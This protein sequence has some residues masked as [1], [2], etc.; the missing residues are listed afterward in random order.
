LLSSPPIAIPIIL[1][2]GL[3]LFI[4]NLGGAPL[5]TKGEPREAVTVFDI[6]H[7]GGV[8]LPLRAGVEIPSKPLLMHWL[9]AIVSLIAGRVSAWTVRLPSATLAIAGMLITYL[10]VR[11]MFEARGALFAALMLGTAF[12]YLQAGTGSR[13][14]MTLTFFMTVAF[15]E[16]LAI[17]ERLSNRTTLLY[18]ALALAVLTK[19]PVGAA[20]PALV[21]F[22]WIALAWRWEVLKRLHLLR[23][24][25][26]VGVIGGGWYLAA[27]VVGG[28]AFVHKQ[29]L[30]EN[31][32]RLIGHA[33]VNHGHAHPFYYEELALLAG[34]MPWTPL[35]LLAIVQAIRHPRRL[36]PRLGYLLV[37][38]LVV[39][40]FYNLPQSK[41]GVYLLAL[42]PALATILALYL[43]DAITHRAMIA[44]PLRAFTRG[45][46]LFFIASGVLA[47]LGLALLFAAP[48]AIGYLL[49]ECGIMLDQLP[50]ALRTTAHQHGIVSLVLPLIA[51]ATGVYLLR[52]RPRIE[53][54]FFA[55]TVGFVA[56]VLAVNLVVEPAVA[57]TLTLE[58]FAAATMRI[59]NGSPVGYWGS[60]DYDFAFYSGRNIQFVTSPDTQ[61]NFVVSSKNDYRLMWPAMRA[62]YQPVLRTGPTDFDGGG[63][64]V[65]LK[66]IDS[67]QPPPA[68]S[69]APSSPA[70]P[71]PAP[72][73]STASAPPN[74]VATAPLPKSAAAAP[75]PKS[76]STIPPPSST[77]T[78]NPSPSASSPHP[79]NSAARS[80]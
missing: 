23:G 50:A 14:D 53:T 42:Y 20:L 63:Q 7:G 59:A 75:L 74:S 31:L 15:F 10:Y 70:A 46:G 5:Y 58:G 71:L 79:A 34:F 69:P 22:V 38:F 2:I 47:T 28:S 32:Y 30:S 64:M 19:G 37:W 33:G 21:A 27:I 48:S 76:S 39:L 78:P 40:I 8:I 55:L 13:V 12:Q 62:R 24:A 16:F 41:R 80:L 66:R 6:V 49:T 45:F 65:L 17:A 4:V 57:N 61:L 26:I 43:S 56:M 44:R 29:L 77:A 3:L 52:A 68:S 11:K 67:P 72:P 25:I 36:D 51:I 73:H 9:A 35:L 18:L 1:A 54:M 60:L